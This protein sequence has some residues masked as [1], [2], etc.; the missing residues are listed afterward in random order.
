MTVPRFDSSFLKKLFINDN[1]FIDPFFEIYQTSSPTCV[2][3]FNHNLS[4]PTQKYYTSFV[5]MSLA[6]IPNSIK[7]DIL[8]VGKISLNVTKTCFSGQSFSVRKH[9]FFDF[10]IQI[11]FPFLV[12]LKIKTFPF[13]HFDLILRTR[14][15]LIM[16][17]LLDFEHLI[18]TTFATFL[19]TDYFYQNLAMSSTSSSDKN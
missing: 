16:K 1:F 5:N 3:V 8:K 9:L 11:I 17:S 15:K 12:F 13:N 2:R 4:P 19:L 14:C 10:M 7:F 18:I 6:L